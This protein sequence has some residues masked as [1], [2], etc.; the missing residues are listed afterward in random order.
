MANLDDDDL[1]N[2]KNLIV[3]SIDEKVEDGT[4]VS[5]EQ[6]SHLPNKEEFHSANAKLMKELKAIRENTSALTK[7]VSNHSD[8]IEKLKKIHSGYRHASV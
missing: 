8:E 3:V 6:I 1:K 2:I 5:G 7:R 4:L